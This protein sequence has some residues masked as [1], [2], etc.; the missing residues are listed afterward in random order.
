M[1]YRQRTKPKKRVWFGGL[2]LFFCFLSSYAFAAKPTPNSTPQAVSIAPSSGTVP[3]NTPATFTSVYSDADGWQNLAKAE[4]LI[5]TST[6]TKNCSYVSYN[7]NTNKLY[8]RNDKGTG[9]LGGFTPGSA[10]IIQNSYVS[11]DCSKSTISGSGTTL[12]VTWSVTFKS[13]FTGTKNLYL[14]VTDDKNASQG[15]VNKGTCAIIVDTV[16]PTGAISVNSDNTYTNSSSVTL[17]LSAQDNPGGSGLSQMQFSNDGTSWSAPESYVTTKP[18]ILTSGDGAETAYVKYS[19]NAGNWSTPYSDTIILD[20]TPPDIIITNPSDNSIVNN[21]NIAVQYT[22][23]GTP[24]TKDT[25]L[26]EG[27]NTITIEETDL[28]GNSASV[29][30]HISLDS[31]P[32]TGAVLTNNDAQYITTASVI[33]SLSAADTATGVTQMQFSNNNIAWSAP[34]NYAESKPWT[35]TAGDGTKTVYVKFKDGAGNWSGAYSDTIILDTTLPVIVITSPSDNFLT[36]QETI[37]LSYTIDGTPY[38]EAR[39]LTE[40]LNTLTVN[41][42]DPAGNSASQSVSGTSDTTV[43]LTPQGLSASA[44]D[45]KADL[46]WNVNTEPDLAGYNIYRSTDNVS[47]AKINTALLTGVSYQDTGLTNGNT[48][49]YKVSA[50]DNAGN[51]STYSN[52]VNA[53]PNAP[54]PSE[55]EPNNDFNSANTIQSDITTAGA[56]NPASDNDYFKITTAQAG[57]LYIYLTN[58]PSNVDA[59]IYLYD[60]NRNLI[61]SQ[62]SGGNGNNVTLERQV[63]SVG[64]Y[65]VRVFDNG[66]NAYS[67]SAYNIRVKFT[68][69]WI[70]NVSASPSLFSPNADGQKDSTTITASITAS[71]NW[72]INIKDSSG[73]LKRTYTGSSASIS[74][75]WDGKDESTAVVTDGTYTYTIDATDPNTGKT[76][77]QV[78]GTV[79]VDTVIDTASIATPLPNA[80]LSDSVAVKVLANDSKFQ[81]YYVYYGKGTSPTSWTNVRAST[82]PALPDAENNPPTIY[83]W[84]TKTLPNGDYVLRLEVWDQANNVRRIE[85]PVR[86]ANAGPD[87]AELTVSPSPF[88][89]DGIDADLTNDVTDITFK[90]SDYG[91]INVSIYDSNL[92][93]VKTLTNGVLYP[94]P[95]DMKVKLPWNGKDNNNQLVR[96]GEY[97]VSVSSGGGNKE[98]HAFVTVNDVPI[99]NN[100]IVSPI[101]FSPDGDGISDTTALAFS[102]S[103]NSTMTVEVYNSQGLLVKTISAS[104]SATAG[105]IY[106]YTWDGKDNGGQVSPQGRYFFKVSAAALTGSQAEPLNMNVYLLYISD[107]HISKDTLNPYLSENTA[108]TYRLTSNAKLSIKIYNAQNNLVRN[109]I[110]D[111]LR[112]AGQ[113]SE[114]WDGKDDSG[115]ILSDGHYY[116]TIEDS[117]GGTAAVVYNPSGTG[118]NDISH[119]ISF[120]TT[121]FDTLK[122]QPCVLTYNLPK[123]AKINIKVR[124]ERYAGPAI[125]VIKYQEDLGSGQHQTIWD[126]RDELGDIIS[127][128]SYTLAIW[129]YTLEDNAFVITGGRPVIS[130]VTVTPIKYD[131][132]LNPYS[133]TAPGTTTISFNLSKEAYV[134]IGIYNANNSLVHSLLNNTLKFSGANS[135]VWDGKNSRGEVLPNGYYRI[136]IQAQK[137]GNYSDVVT[138][139]TE[140]I[141]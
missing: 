42:T 12:S 81:S 122:N 41:A 75:T 92:N 56:I 69:L 89:P 4:L 104:A 123:P 3:I 97:K 45:A 125:R 136:E 60:G 43:P 102:L 62:Y 23:D 95:T 34:E 39:T 36:N 129:G 83:T 128:K 131:P 24:K 100:S 126:G 16:A 108:I 124:A 22:V 28:A 7:Q 65:Y 33:L 64:D 19:D 94:N 13:T 26:Q 57:K 127:N 48:Y 113:Y 61:T 14:Y 91:F 82:T 101:T 40:G 73:A 117:L 17:I 51:E 20:T 80:D 99:F 70:Y 96:N 90:L 66:N 46:S 106:S 134:N 138:G 54:L 27:P 118:G 9:W 105:Q 30:V 37:S 132:L 110:T 76:A 137:D 53:T 85:V 130:Q 25:T 52:A 88:T 50:K 103:E 139:H 79:I 2:V 120:S 111:Q 107:I 77:S 78:S 55:T 44:G 112:S 18:W 116:F 8:L 71:S 109:I 72:A 98:A 133:L 74:R 15:W 93:L 1:P 21:P 114:T 5:N 135:V 141:Y 58:V 59:Y 84:D 140:V 119:S 29:N 49:Y 32:P 87:I 31:V 11:L 38:S 10:G 86:I 115:N 63:S 35:L 47:Y 68:T 121:T 67:A 6:T